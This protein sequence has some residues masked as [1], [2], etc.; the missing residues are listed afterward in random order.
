MDVGS[1]DAIFSTQNSTPETAIL[2][3]HEQKNYVSQ[4]VDLMANESLEFKQSLYDPYNSRVY[5]NNIN[6]WYGFQENN[7]QW[8][9]I[10]TFS[11]TGI[12][13]VEISNDGT[14]LYL[15]KTHI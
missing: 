10:D 5:F 1:L 8:Q 9:K 13:G 15:T 12:N 4:V 11:F 14:K 3:V 6:G 2:Y 7:G